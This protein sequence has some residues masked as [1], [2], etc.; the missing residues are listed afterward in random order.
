MKHPLE[1]LIDAKIAAAQADGAF[2]NLEGMGKPLAPCDAPEN[3][4]F[5]KVVRNHGGVPEFVVLARELADMRTELAETG[6]R[7]RR[8]E[9][10]K[11]MSMMEAKIDIARKQFSR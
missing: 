6:D 5:S 4:L 10:M 9:I 2:D 3:I 1:D 8:M 11:E 7:T